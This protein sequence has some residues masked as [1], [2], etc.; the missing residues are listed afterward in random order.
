M[1]EYGLRLNAKTNEKTNKAVEMYNEGDVYGFS[2]A[3]F[4][5]GEAQEAIDGEPT[6][7]T[8]ILNSLASR[9]S[10]SALR[11]VVLLRTNVVARTLGSPAGR[12]NS[13]EELRFVVKDME[14]LTLGELKEDEEHNA[15]LVKNAC[16]SARALSP[17]GKAHIFVINYESLLIDPFT[18][19]NR[20]VLFLGAS[21]FNETEIL[22]AV[23][24]GKWKR[25]HAS[26]IYSDVGFKAISDNLFLGNKFNVTKSIN[27]CYLH[28]ALAPFPR[29]E[30]VCF[31]GCIIPSGIYVCPSETKQ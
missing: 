9:S 30:F 10:P 6:N 31:H 25:K 23:E 13:Q 5:Y 11:N 3:D 2:Y 22:K 21:G 29:E 20:L 16:R 4:Q 1:F 7:W 18:W 17:S 12:T 14:K 28:Q 8:A 15:G 27:D 24:G 19:F 26:T